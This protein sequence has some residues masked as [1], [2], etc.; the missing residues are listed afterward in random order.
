MF[1]GGVLLP[2][3]RVVF[4]PFDS[5]TVGLFDPSTSTYTSVNRYNPIQRHGFS[6]GVLLPDGRV[7]FVPFHSSTVGL[8][9]PSTNTFTSGSNVDRQYN[10]VG[11]VSLPDGRV[12]FV[13][14]HFA[15]IGLF[16]PRTSATRKPAYTLSQPLPPSWNVALLP[17]YNQL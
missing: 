14:D 10:F 13:P 4:V 6:G 11:G 7:V 9:D 2:D 3:G 8:F 12:V 15:R 16:D 17:Y 5:T 1:R